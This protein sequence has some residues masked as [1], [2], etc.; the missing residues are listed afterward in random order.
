[1]VRVADSVVQS[2]QRFAVEIEITSS[3]ANRVGI[4]AAIGVPEIWRF[5]GKTLRFCSL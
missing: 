5:D 4:C 1:M 3:L 2:E